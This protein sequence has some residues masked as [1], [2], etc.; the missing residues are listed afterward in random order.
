[1]QGSLSSTSPTRSIR[2]IATSDLGPRLCCIDGSKTCR[3][4]T[5]SPDFSRLAVV[6]PFPGIHLM[7]N[8]QRQLLIAK[9]QRSAA[10]SLIRWRMKGDSHGWRASIRASPASDSSKQR[11]Y[12]YNQQHRAQYATRKIA[13]AS[14]IRP[15]WQSTDQQQHQNNK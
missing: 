14:A 9:P 11:H 13:P 1:M 3:R 12:Q 6:G 15:S 4:F 2:A 5:G 10:V 8:D 7:Q